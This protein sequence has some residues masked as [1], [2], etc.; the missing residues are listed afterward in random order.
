MISG[1]ITVF[2][3]IMAKKAD[4]PPHFVL[5]SP[6][7][8]IVF[9]LGGVFSPF[10]ATYFPLTCRNGGFSPCAGTSAHI[11]H[12]DFPPQEWPFQDRRVRVDGFPFSRRGFGRH[13][14][15]RDCAGLSSVSVASGVA[16]G[17]RGYTGLLCGAQSSVR[18]FQSS[19]RGAQSSVRGTQSSV[20]GVQSSVRGAQSSVRGA[21]SSVRGAQS[22]VRGAQSSVR[23]S[24]SSVRSSQSSAA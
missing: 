9:P 24:Q 14:A 18:G 7:F 20:R 8:A 13:C 10:F 22:S 1:E 2:G 4:P 6:L 16:L 11:K 15:A 19:V 21:Q 5:K 23:S 12:A 3:V 17:T